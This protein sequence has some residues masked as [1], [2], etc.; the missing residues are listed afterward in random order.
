MGSP[1]ETLPKKSGVGNVRVKLT[2]DIGVIKCEGHIVV[3]CPAKIGCEQEFDA[4]NGCCIAIKG[5]ANGA[6]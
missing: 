6:I 2:V 3:A 5:V 4:L 1:F